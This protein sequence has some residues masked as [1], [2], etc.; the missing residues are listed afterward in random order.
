MREIRMSGSEGGGAKQLSLPLLLVVRF[1][2]SIRCCLIRVRLEFSC[3]TPFD[4]VRITLEHAT[5]QII[6]GA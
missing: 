4:K 6:H 5:S 3:K 1:A 2:D